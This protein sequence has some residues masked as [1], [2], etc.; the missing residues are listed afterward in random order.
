MNR[1]R[2]LAGR[3]WLV[4]GVGFTLSGAA[5]IPSAEAQDVCPPGYYYDPAYDCV[6]YSY[7]TWPYYAYPDYGFGFFYG[8]G[9]GGGWGG[10]GGRGYHGGGGYRGGGHGGGGGR[11]GGGVHH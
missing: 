11:G 9:W 7:L 4:L 5:L 2:S 3:I 1:A 10:R 6:P 8:P